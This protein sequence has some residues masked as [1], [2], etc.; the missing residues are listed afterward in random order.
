MSAELIPPL[1]YWRPGGPLRPPLAQPGKRHAS[2]YRP[3]KR[4]DMNA[5]K[6]RRRE[7]LEASG[8]TCTRFDESERAANA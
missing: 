6:D 7:Y 3:Q 4:H 1:F 8:K 2:V 5:W